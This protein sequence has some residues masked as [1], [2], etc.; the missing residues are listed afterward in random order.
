[1]CRLTR[2]PTYTLVVLTSRF[3]CDYSKVGAGAYPRVQAL[4]HIAHLRLLS[5]RPAQP[6]S[7]DL[8]ELDGSTQMLILYPNRVYYQMIRI[9]LEKN[10]N[11]NEE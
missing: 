10:T 4:G 8:A 3:P 5:W 6:P 9:H 11:K 2:T 1:M 7:K